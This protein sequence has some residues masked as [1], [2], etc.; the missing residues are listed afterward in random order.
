MSSNLTPEERQRI[1]EE[2]RLRNE[3]TL[4]TG[5]QLWVKMLLIFGGIIVLIMLCSLIFGV[6]ALNS[7]FGSLF[8]ITQ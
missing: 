8:Q 1:V 3:E 5:M 6:A 4:R 7:I 2:Q